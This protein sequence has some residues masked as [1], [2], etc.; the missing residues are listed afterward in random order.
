[1]LYDFA[2]VGGDRRQAYLANYLKNRRYRVIVYGIE[3]EH[4]DRECKAAKSFSE[5]VTQAECIIGPVLFSK[6]GKTLVAGKKK[7]KM[8]LKE[9]AEY[10]KEGQKVFGGCISESVE[11]KLREKKIT[12]Y[13]FMKMDDVAIYN[14]IATA[15]GAIVKAMELKPVNLHE[16]ACLVLGYG[17]CAKI[18]ASKLKGLNAKVTICAR[19]K[20]D[21][22]LAEAFGLK[23]MD[24]W[25]LSRRI[26]RFDY[27]FNTVPAI[28]LK[29]EEL[30][31]MLK[32]ACIVDIASF[33]GGADRKTVKEMDICYYFCPSLPGI[34]APKSSGIRLAEKV[35]ELKERVE[36]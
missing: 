12:V 25:H 36:K 21:R 4:L 7:V 31:R 6:D 20:A 28:V 2:V 30:K 33:P 10:L 22:S 26:A 9:L 15:E 16:S 24:F 14:A 1:V 19:S 29:R 34:Y 8:E 11:A 5:A 17:R 23:T 32:G 27:I 3:E 18:L 13:D 35:L